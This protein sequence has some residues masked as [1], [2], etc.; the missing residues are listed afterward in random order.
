MS[1]KEEIDQ[2]LMTRIIESGPSL[3]VVIIDDTMPELSIPGQSLL[4]YGPRPS[5]DVHYSQNDDAW[6]RGP[7]DEVR[8]QVLQM[9][10][11]FG[12][13]DSIGKGTRSRCTVIQAVFS[14]GTVKIL[15]T[16]DI[17]DDDDR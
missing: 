12:K 5:H 3:P 8:E 7:N 14:N 4:K 15:E 10:R 16:K 11:R 6:G 9:G 2:R 17:E 13:N 1:D